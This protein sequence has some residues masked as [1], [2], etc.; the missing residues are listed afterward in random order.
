[1]TLQRLR[2]EIKAVDEDIIRLIKRRQEISHKIALA[3]KETDTAVR[4]E[5]RAQ[6]VIDNAVMTGMKAGLNPVLVREVFSLFIRMSEELQYQTLN[7][8]N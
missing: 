4:D 3:K 6:E 2:T 7:E 1:M 5:T 8:K